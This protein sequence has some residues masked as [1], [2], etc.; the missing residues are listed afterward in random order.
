MDDR[1]ASCM[2]PLSLMFTFVAGGLA[3]A[4]VALLLAPNSGKATRERMRRSVGEAAGSARD[5]KDQLVRRGQTIRDEA[6]HR[7]DGAVSALA[8]DESANLRG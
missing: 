2:S 8:G 5:L 1:A 6:R 4:G 7:V 3:G